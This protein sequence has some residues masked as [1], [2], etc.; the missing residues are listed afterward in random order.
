MMRLFSRVRSRRDWFV[1]LIV[2]LFGGIALVENWNAQG[3]L[4]LFFMTAFAILVP[5]FAIYLALNFAV[6]RQN[7]DS[8]RLEGFEE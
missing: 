6:L 1:S 2:L 4:G 5:T 7:Q 8:P 3:G